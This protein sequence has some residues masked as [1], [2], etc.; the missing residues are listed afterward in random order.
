MPAQN[1][2]FFV[3]FYDLNLAHNVYFLTEDFLESVVK[4]EKSVFSRRETAGK[5]ISKNMKNK[6]SEQ[7]FCGTELKNGFEKSKHFTTY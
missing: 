6:E 7:S 1:D 3:F 4:R 5:K 2:G